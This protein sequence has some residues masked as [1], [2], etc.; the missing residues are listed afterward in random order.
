[1]RRTGMKGHWVSRLGR[2]DCGHRHR[3]AD[4]AE[5]CLLK[6]RRAGSRDLGAVS[7][8]RSEPPKDAPEIPAVSQRSTTGGPGTI[9]IRCRQSMWLLEGDVWIC[10]GCDLRDAG[11]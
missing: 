3:D 8:V 11:R 2:L 5:Q 1:M 10:G 9:C 6:R 4:A 7:F